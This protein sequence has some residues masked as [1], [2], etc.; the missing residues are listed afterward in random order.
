[1]SVYFCILQIVKEQK[2]RMTELITC[3]QEMLSELRE[4]VKLL[5]SEGNTRSKLEARFDNLQQV[6]MMDGWMD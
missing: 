6:W 5:E 1:M 2:V 4:K 3:R